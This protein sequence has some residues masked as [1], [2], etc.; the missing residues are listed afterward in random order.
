[1]KATQAGLHAPDVGRD[2]A[3]LLQHCAR[4]ERTPDGQRQVDD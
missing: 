1:M 3:T 4:Y 2:M